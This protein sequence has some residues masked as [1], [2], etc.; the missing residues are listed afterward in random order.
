MERLERLIGQLLSIGVI[1]AAAVTGL[2]GVILLYRHGFEPV[3]YLS[4][5]GE[6]NFLR[7]P[8]GIGAGVLGLSGRAIVQLGISVLVF[9]QLIRVALTLWLFLRLHDRTFTLISAWILVMLLFSLVW[10]H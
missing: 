9:V 5:H 2:G 1:I 4:F 7:S 10:Q 6:P 8:A 3:S